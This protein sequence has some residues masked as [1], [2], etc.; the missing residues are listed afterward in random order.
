MKRR[1]PIQAAEVGAR[2][3][4][5]LQPRR[6]DDRLTREARLAKA[7]DFTWFCRYYLPDYFELPPAAFHAELAELVDTQERV[8]VAAPREHAKSTIVSFAKVLHSI[9]CL[10]AHFIVIFRDSEAI[11]K[12]NVD[13][14]RQELEGNERIQTDFGDL[15][16]GRKWAEGEFITANDVKVLGRGRDQ[17]VRGLRF[18]QHRP[19]L[20]ILDDVEDDEQ[21]DS[22]QQC[23]K[24]ERRIRRSILNIIGPQG[25]FFMVGT[26][27]SHNSVLTR[28]LAQT[29]VF[30]TRTLRAIQPDGKPLWPAR[31]PLARLEAKRKEIG[32]RAFATEFMNE[33]ANEEEQIFSPNGWRYFRDADIADLK[34]DLVAAIDPAIGLKQ[35]ND[36]TAVAVVGGANGN[37]YVLRL[38][39]KRLKVQAQVE[40]VLS[41]CREWGRILKFGFETIAYQTALKQLVEDA[42]AQ[43]N[44]QVPAVAVEDISSDKLRRL[45]TLAPLV[46]QGRLFFP[47]ASSSYWTPDVQKCL[48]E[49]EAL[50]CSTSA[51][52][53]GP[54]AVE[55]AIKLLRGGRGKKGRVWMA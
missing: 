31:W 7:V 29:D 8:V 54:D 1:P 15:V 13:D 17:S 2:A 34:L 49:F 55:R 46:E 48:D 28:F 33:A 40:L 42:S 24:L 41:T 11:A 43:Q 44:L 30:V 22:R 10:R 19:D 50:G 25:R 32:A 26:V 27:L 20:V 35:K 37:Y 23:D 51:H 18:K 5:M 3:T 4:A 45:S 16:G 6:P 39:I 14:I 36:E 47:S 52:D 53:D 38:V 9:C 12:Q 21:A